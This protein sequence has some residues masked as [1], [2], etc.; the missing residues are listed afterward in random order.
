MANIVII[1]TQWGDEGKGKIV[2][3]LAADADMVVRFQGGNNAGHTMVVNGKQ[4]ISHLVPSGILQNKICIIGN[5]MVVDP[6]VLLNEIEYL[7]KNHIDIGPKNLKIS[8]RAHLIMPYHKQIDMAREQ[9]QG[10]KKIG[11]TGRGI[12]PAYEDKAARRGL[13]FVDLLE[14]EIFSENLRMIL[15]EKNF[16]LS[17]YLKAQPLD[18]TQIQDKYL[19]YGE[20]FSPY[21]ANVSLLIHEAIQQGKQVLFEGAQGTHLDIDQG[22]Y[23]FVTSSNT[24]SGN[25]CCGSGIG[26]KDISEVIGIVKAYTTRVGQGPFPTELTDSIGDR[27]Q[28]KGAEFGAT[29]GRKRRCGWLDAI[30]LK[31]AVRLNGITGFAITKL[32][33][34]GGLETIK[35]CIGYEYQGVFRD[36]F[37]TSIHVLSNCRPIYETLPG[38]SEDISSVRSY[39]DLPQHTKIY[40]RRIEEITGVPNRIISVGPGRDQTI[41][42][43]N[44]FRC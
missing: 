37:P 39:E 6:E 13:R 42:I 22:T 9:K 5:G 19:K 28:K 8:E 40:L 38:W 36:D 30:T 2:D 4:F 43:K 1:G 31:N 33:V 21:I 35:I 3:L 23:P 14:P 25:A 18:F 10:D 17:H 20:I 32:D 24:L 16:Y 12:G 34:L 27:I 11:T 44:P 29:T 7:K 26:P 15:E 41:V